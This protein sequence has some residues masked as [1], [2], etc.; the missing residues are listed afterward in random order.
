MRRVLLA[1]VFALAACGSDP[2]ALPVACG[3]AP[4]QVERALGRAPAAV[5]LGDATKLS[6]C[7]RDA[8]S[9]ADLQS[10]GVAFQA[11]AARLRV[12]AD[13]GEEQAAVALGYLAGAA[14]KGAATTQG[15]SSELAVRL[16]RLAGRLIDRM[17]AARAAV[18]RGLRAGE[19]L[20]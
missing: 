10:V 19:R 17:P 3:P 20:G 12:R 7:V 8:D 9:S 6:D 16:A 4:E 11:A 13:T 5:T 15:V 18:Q 2:A 1:L 14:R